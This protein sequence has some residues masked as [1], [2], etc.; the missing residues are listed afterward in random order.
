MARSYTCRLSAFL[1]PINASV[2]F[3]HLTIRIEANG[4][5]R[6]DCLALPALPALVLIRQY[7]PILLIFVYCPKRAGLQA[8]SAVGASVADIFLHLCIL[9]QRLFDAAKTIRILSLRRVMFGYAG[10]IAG[11]APDTNIFIKLYHTGLLSSFTASILQKYP[12]NPGN[13]DIGSR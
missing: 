5:I 2:A 9:R 1:K 6:A 10:H 3:F 12:L 11:I 4:V 8:F 13:P 7:Q